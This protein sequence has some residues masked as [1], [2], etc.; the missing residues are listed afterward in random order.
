MKNILFILLAFLAL[1]SCKTS[2]TPN[3]SVKKEAAS[4]SKNDT[5]R[6]ANDSLEYEITI[7]DNG[8]NSWLLTNARPRKFYSQQFLEA[9]NIIWVNE[10]N[11]RVMQ[12]MNYNP[13]LY[14]MTI[15]YRS[16]ID[17]G[18]E[19]NYLLFNYL[20]Y[21]QIVNRQRLGVFSARI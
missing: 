7:I 20:T 5:I 19:V 6:I 2:K 10:W 1:T 9:R 15:D 17:Y 12:P 21:F 14:Q 11:N 8:F 13:E 18:Y 16:G 4:A 3:N